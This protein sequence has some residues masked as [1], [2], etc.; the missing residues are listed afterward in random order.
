VFQKKVP[1]LKHFGIFSLW[2]SL[3]REILQTLYVQLYAEVLNTHV[4]YDN[5]K[6]EKT[7]YILNSNHYNKVINESKKK[8]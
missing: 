1:P 5:S 7:E 6:D 3:F 2:L 4:V 8:N